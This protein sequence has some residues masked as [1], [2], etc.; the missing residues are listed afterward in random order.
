[1]SDRLT[2]G[3]FTIYDAMPTNEMIDRLRY[4]RCYPIIF[5]NKP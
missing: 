4:A 1:M 3:S 5:Y 2:A